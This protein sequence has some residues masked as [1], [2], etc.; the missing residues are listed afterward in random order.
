[1]SA[2]LS[3]LFVRAQPLEP[4]TKVPAG[5]PVAQPFAE[6]QKTAVKVSTL[7]NG[8]KVATY[9]PIPYPG[10][11]V[12]VFVNAGARYQT[13]SNEGSVNVLRELLF[14][15]NKARTSVE[16]VR[17]L[18]AASPSFSVSVSR[19]HLVA[20]AELLPSEVSNFTSLLVD[21]LGGIRLL[22]WEVR[23]AIAEAKAVREAK[24]NAQ[25]VIQ[26]AVFRTAFRG[27]GIGR[28]LYSHSSPS[29]DA[30]RGFVGDALSAD[31][32]TVVGVNLD[33]D[34]FLKS[35]EKNFGSF[36]SRA[37]TNLDTSASVYVGGQTELVGGGDTA[38]VYAFNGA[39]IADQQS[40]AFLVL[41]FILGGGSSSAYQPALGT[42]AGT[43][44]LGKLTAQNDWLSSASSFNYA[45]RDAGL[46]GVYA[47]A[48]S[49]NGAK[50]FSNVQSSLTSLPNAINDQMVAGAKARAKSALLGC[51]SRQ[52]LLHI[53]GQQASAGNNAAA[54][55]PE[56][57]AAAI[58]AV[59]AQQL[60]DLAKQLVNSTPTIVAAGDV[61]QIPRV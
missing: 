3:R 40:A 61:S 51:D 35:I 47:A 17:A 25:S 50:L 41:K 43:S 16:Q 53:V 32:I 18:E 20:S 5:L 19:E 13:S 4:L 10:S 58:D 24:K 56:K 29:V 33:H 60:K 57:L 45:L 54:H 12:G 14:K 9:G 48:R 52:H 7:S 28:S 36:S 21:G 2:L 37:P 11:T 49:G 15:G 30:V 38:L 55:S 59:T 6:T 44:L 42:G 1:M 23:D 34:S 26:D 31:R 8:V 27:T 39:S 22:G 46:F